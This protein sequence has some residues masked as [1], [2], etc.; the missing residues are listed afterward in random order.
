MEKT[1]DNAQQDDCLQSYFLQIKNIPLLTFED[2]LELSRRIQDGDKV[3][4]CRLVEANLR[5]VVKIARAYLTHDV[6][7]MDL[8]QEGNMGLMR[9]VDKYNYLKQVRFSTYAVWWIR[10]AITRYLADKKRT[11]RLPHRKED[12]L[13]KVQQAYYS[14]SQMYMRQ[15]KVKEIAAEIGASIKDV[16]F[17]LGFAQGIVSFEAVREDNGAVPVL[18]YLEDYTYN[19][20]RI[21]FEKSSREATLRV[22]DQL[23]DR[24][25][26]IITYR[27]Q[28]YGEKRYSLKNIG[29]K[30]GLSSETVRQIEFKALRKLRFN[31]EE[32]RPYIEAM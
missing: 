30:M 28:L 22:L 31:E 10:Q 7:L 21:L 19:P 25:K 18:E 11:I 8:I 1:K 4:R 23:K 6:S 12:I 24:E 3:A 13:R 29:I 20:E 26:R 5:L 14:L 16:E 17:I 27:Y 2:E 9:A 32:L 15:P